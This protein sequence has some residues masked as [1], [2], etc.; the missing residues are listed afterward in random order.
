MSADISQRIQ[1]LYSRFGD[2]AGVTIEIHKSLIAI[3]ILNGAGEATIFLQGAQISHFKSHHQPDS[4][5]LSP[6][7]EYKVGQSL[8]GGIPICWPWFGELSKNPAQIQEQ[9]DTSNAPAHGFVRERD[10]QLD[11]IE[12]IDANTTR[13]TLSLNIEADAEP[14]WPFKCRLELDIIIAEHLSVTFR[15]FNLSA[16]TFHFSTALHSYFSVPHISQVAVTGLEQSQYLDCL[17][18]WQ[19][20]T[21]VGKVSIGQEVDRLYYP[22]KNHICIENQHTGHSLCIDSQNSNSAVLWNPWVDKARRLSAFA[23]DAYQ[24]MLCIETANAGK[25]F[26]SLPAGQQHELRLMISHQSTAP[27]H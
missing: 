8:R 4:L 22:T 16:Q 26:V 15:V 14:L 11:R 2:I 10:W 23:D 24:Q 21:Q 13:A 12:A 19:S 5:W 18:D 20:Q 9:I 6:E 7:C 3:N 27:S 17:D 25:D 1:K